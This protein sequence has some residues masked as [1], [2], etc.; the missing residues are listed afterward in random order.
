M[1]STQQITI[2]IVALSKAIMKV[3]ALI[4]LPYVSVLARHL[5]PALT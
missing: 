1:V 2:I 5:V 3:I 4:R